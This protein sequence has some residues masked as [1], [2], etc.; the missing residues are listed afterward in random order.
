MMRQKVNCALFVQTRTW[1]K[2]SHLYLKTRVDSKTNM[3]RI[4]VTNKTTVGIIILQ[5]KQ[6][7]GYFWILINS[8]G[9]FNET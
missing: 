5:V 9:H 7:F 3:I 8:I 2:L 6:I 1:C 4:T